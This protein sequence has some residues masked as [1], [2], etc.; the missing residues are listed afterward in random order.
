M[1]WKR[2]AMGGGGGHDSITERGL[3]ICE[4]VVISIL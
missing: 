2:V 3:E 4:K 1:W